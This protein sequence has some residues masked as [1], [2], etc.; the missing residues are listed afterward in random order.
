MIA[1]VSAEVPGYTANL[2]PSLITDLA[3][4]ATMAIAL[5]DSAMVDLINSVS[6][7]GANV[8]LLY[9]LGGIYGVTRGVGANT[10]VSVVF[11][12]S[13]GFVITRGLTLS[14]GNHQYVVQ[15]NA[16]IP[17]SGQSTSVFCLASS[18]G[19]WAV[20]AGTVTQIITSIPSIVTLSVSN[21]V[22]GSP[23]LD[24]QSDYEYRAQVW[25][26]GMMA[27]QGTPD[28]LK[29]ALYRVP[30][31]HPNQ[32]SYRQV[33]LGKWAVICG[34]GDPYEVAQAIHESIPDISVLTVD[35]NN[36]SGYVPPYE[37]VTIEDHPDIY[38]ISYII[39]TSQS[40]RII[41]TWNTIGFNPIDPATVEVLADPAIVDY[42]NGIYVG[43]P[44]SIYQIQTVFQKA[45]SSVINPNQ[46]SLIDVKVSIDNVL[47]EPDPNTGLISGDGYKFFTTDISGVMVQHFEQVG[48]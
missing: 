42:I 28:N 15:H 40:V 4:T 19:A 2:P 25:R 32:V 14:D 29:T 23:G 36:P 26:A 47:R 24:A 27:V 3:S 8:P 46:I 16:I 11:T 17:S 7:Y 38:D 41:L 12:G 39:P 44:I 30:G 18:P 45:V 35:V 37:R 31:V 6:P 34:G 20:P 13:P 9:Q 43:K 22:E 21:I 33:S 1:L 10:S 5:I 48:G